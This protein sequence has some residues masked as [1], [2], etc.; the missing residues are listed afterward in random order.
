M[1]KVKIDPSKIALAIALAFD[2]TVDQMSQAF[3][4]AIETEL[5]NYPRVTHRR[6]GEI[7][8][9]PRNIVDT[10]ELLESKVVARSSSSMSAK[11]TW[12]ASH[13]IYAH[14]GYTTRSGAEVPPRRW[15]EKG[16]EV[17][18]PKQ[19]FEQRLRRQL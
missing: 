8:S 11:F 19:A 6:S 4:E 14:E 3:D 17:C 18:D 10:G 9:S 12:E 2:N 15:T 5:Y 7:V 16:L 1:A 13:S